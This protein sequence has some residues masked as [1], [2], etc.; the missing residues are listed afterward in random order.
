MDVGKV[1]QFAQFYNQHCVDQDVLIGCE[2]GTAL[3]Q[4][5]PSNFAH[6]V[7][8]M[9]HK[10][11][12]MTPTEIFESARDGHLE[13]DLGKL[14]INAKY[15]T[16]KINALPT[17]AESFG[18][19]AYLATY[20]GRNIGL[21]SNPY[22][23]VSPDQTAAI[24]LRPTS[25]LIRE[26]NAYQFNEGVYA[27]VMVRDLTQEN[28]ADFKCHPVQGVY[29]I[30]FETEQ[31]QIDY[32]DDTLEP[33]AFNLDALKPSPEWMGWNSRQQ[34]RDRDTGFATRSRDRFYHSSADLVDDLMKELE[35]KVEEAH[36]PEL[37]GP[38]P[39]E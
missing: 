36:P 23:L 11:G 7:G 2:L 1:E 15:G 39:S 29:K 20:H 14:L 31:L 24:G 13:Q 25:R 35:P 5:R 3:V 27:P 6:L 32:Q 17:L 19:G 22:Y 10:K 33:S 12:A 16:A 9:P 18:E 8:L 21:K 30:P 37:T 34:R 28:L 26:G 38:S 4:F